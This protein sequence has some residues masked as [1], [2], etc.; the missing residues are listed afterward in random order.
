[1]KITVSKGKGVQNEI[2]AYYREQ[3]LSEQFQKGE[4]LPTVRAL[5]LALS[6]S[7]LTVTRAY[8]KLADEQL[9]DIVQGSGTYV[10]MMSISENSSENRRV[11]CYDWMLTID[12]NL[13]RTQFAAEFSVEHLTKGYNMFTSLMHWEDYPHQQIRRVLEKIVREN[14]DI[15]FQYSPVSGD[16]LTRRAVANYLQ[17]MGNLQIKASD[18]M[19]TSGSQ[20][21]L[22]MI[23][24]TFIKPGDTVLMETPTFPG[25]I[26]AFQNQGC[27]ICAIPMETDGID[28]N[29]F[30]QIVEKHHPKMLYLT[31]NLNN[32]TGIVTS[33]A[34]REIILETARN[35]HMIIVE[36]DPWC[37]L[38][39]R[40]HS[41]GL[42]KSY[43]HDGHVI[44]VKGFSKLVGPGFRVGAVIAQG[45][46]YNR[47]VAAKANADLGSPLL[48]Q[49]LLA[50][51]VSTGLLEQT[52]EKLRTL[53]KE[54]WALVYKTLQNDAPDYLKWQL[55]D[56]GVNLWLSL[57]TYLNTDIF[58]K[59]YCHP[60][61]LTF[62]TGRLCY[63]NEPLYNQCRMSFSALRKHEI[64]PA[65]KL[66]CTLLKDYHCDYSHDS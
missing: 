64:E 13:R 14:P 38:M 3:I 7:P 4:K 21:A 53:I 45:T 49:R 18:V 59:S 16:N 36:D 29:L 56:G 52:T 60:H 12:D 20:Q 5:A 11:N 27:T 42:L 48:T 25:A 8:K 31:P 34:K 40:R 37:E 62:L 10:S 22:N 9:V 24:R 2:V 33:A 32:P 1:M 66:F 28:I 26:D 6:V 55:P 41:V 44:L 63:P 19:M 65:V 35:A 17:R 50:E 30:E 15:L 39:D 61:N 47:L 43:D 54:K 23:A 51:I 57:P 58:L 46:I